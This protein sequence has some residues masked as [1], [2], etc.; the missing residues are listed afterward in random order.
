MFWEYIIKTIVVHT[1]TYF[2]VGFTAFNIFKYSAT[3]SDPKSNMRPATDPLVR[4]GILFQPIRG[5]LFG[6]L[7]FLLRDVLIVQSNGW[8]IA[9]L[10]FVIAGIVGTFAPTASSLEGFIYLKPGAGTNWG[11]L[12]EILTRSFLL[13][14]ITV[15][16]IRHP[17]VGWLNWTM[18]VVF[19]FSLALPILGLL[20][21][22]ER[23]GSDTISSNESN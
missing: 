13:S 23:A 3:L 21:K 22:P 20:A 10:M 11:G 15:L 2:M 9:W 18:G 1:S 12:I 16:W 14:L 5:F 4:A 8:L 17:D 6:I 19:F 7:I